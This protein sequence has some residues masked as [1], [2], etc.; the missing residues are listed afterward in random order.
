MT[1][2]YQLALDYKKGVERNKF[3]LSET[4]NNKVPVSSHDRLSAGV[5]SRAGVSSSVPGS[6]LGEIGAHESSK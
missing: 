3:R 2:S 1:V 5:K 6:L 4:R